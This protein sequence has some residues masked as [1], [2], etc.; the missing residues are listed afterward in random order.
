VRV[1][2]LRLS[3]YPFAPGSSRTATQ[4][5]PFPSQSFCF[6]TQPVLSPSWSGWLFGPP[7]GA[8]AATGGPDE[9]GHDGGGRV[10]EGRDDGGRDS[11]GHGDDAGRDGGGRVDGGCDGAGLANR[12]WDGGT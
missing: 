2:A 1:T 6:L 10:D 8:C 11:G 4:Y 12:G 5:F 9:P 7:I 3:R